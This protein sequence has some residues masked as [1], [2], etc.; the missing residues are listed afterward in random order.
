MIYRTFGAA[1][2][3]TIG[4]ALRRVTRR[5]GVLL[6]AGADPAL[7]RSIGADGVHLPERLAHRAAGIRG[8][9]PRWIVTAAAHGR[10]AVLAAERG[11]AQAVLLSPVFHSASAS[12]GWPLGPVRFAALTR[13]SRL[14]VYA[15]G[16]INARTAARLRGSGAIGVA[17]VEALGKFG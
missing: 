16:G 11:G 4:L 13:G 6:L 2:A 9:N 7:A 5:R 8:R 10:T 17:A 3:V 12:A 14:P 1:D 15:L